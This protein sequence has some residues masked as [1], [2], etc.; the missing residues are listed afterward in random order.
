MIM[1][2][3]PNVYTNLFLIN[4]G[5]IDSITYLLSDFTYENRVMLQ[6]LL[7]PF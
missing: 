5:V 7:F 4:D 6:S 2:L 3:L 1:S